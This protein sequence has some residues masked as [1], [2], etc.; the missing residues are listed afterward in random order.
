MGPGNHGVHI[1]L[2][3]SQ[4]TLLLERLEAL[5]GELGM[6]AEDL[7]S[8]LRGAGVAPFAEPDTSSDT[9]PETAKDPIAAG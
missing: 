3:S 2:E 4:A 6:V 9:D 7:I 5:R 8:L 1:D